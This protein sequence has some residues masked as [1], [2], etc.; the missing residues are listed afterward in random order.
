MNKLIIIYTAALLFSGCN[1]FTASNTTFTPLS[2]GAVSTTTSAGPAG[3][4]QVQLTWGTSS[5][6]PSGYQVEQSLDNS[7]FTQVKQVGLVTTTTVMGLASNKTYYFR[8]RSF[9]QG[10]ESPYS[11][12][13]TVITDN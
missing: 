8:V 1:P 13:I 12:T 7:T 6:L 3:T 4:K 9:N 11:Q 10:G 2:A 5:G